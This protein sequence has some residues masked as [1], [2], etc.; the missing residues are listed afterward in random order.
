MFMRQLLLIVGIFLF[1]NH[2]SAQSAYEGSI[3]YSK[4]K[5]Q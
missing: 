3:E 2:L 5:Q 4:K 1:A